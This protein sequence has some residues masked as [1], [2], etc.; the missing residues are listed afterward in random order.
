MLQPTRCLDYPRQDPVL[1][2]IGR[3]RVSVLA[4]VAVTIQLSNVSIH[5]LMLVTGKQISPEPTIS[6]SITAS[7]SYMKNVVC[8]NL[9]ALRPS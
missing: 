4:R 7:K 9:N 5:R 3:H 6:P 1:G 8:L 2:T